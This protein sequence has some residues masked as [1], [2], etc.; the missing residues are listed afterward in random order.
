[1]NTNSESI[2]SII[3]RTKKRL[4]LSNK[5]NYYSDQFI[6]DLLLDERNLL[7]YRELN[8]KKSK[9]KFIWKTICM[10]LV[11]SKD[12]PCDCIP[13]ELG[14]VVLKSKYKIPKPLNSLT[15]T[16]MKVLSLDGY[17]EYSYKEV[18]NGKFNKYSRNLVF[19]P[20]YTMYNDYLYL[21]GVPN[22][23]LPAVLIEIIPK[24]PSELDNI[25]L[26]DNSGNETGG[27]C[28]DP[29]TDTFNTESYL[30]S[31]IIDNVF[32]KL[33]GSLK[34]PVNLSNDQ[35]NLIKEIQN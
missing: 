14:C 6:Y 28:F 23:D 34:L 27:T 26:C 33:T 31:T 20:Y 35:N 12:I 7:M 10:P 32:E 29:L 19:Q 5:N 9:N 8:K 21:I 24:D 22:L 4:H 2:L 17:K 1:M 13:S 11:K 30:I 25:S 16:M 18:R 3:D 15:G